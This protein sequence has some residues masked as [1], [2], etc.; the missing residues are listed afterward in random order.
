MNCDCQRQLVRELSHPSLFDE[1]IEAARNACVAGASIASALI[2]AAAWYDNPLTG[3]PAVRE[4]VERLGR[5][6]LDRAAVVA[7]LG[8]TTHRA[9]DEQAHGPGFGF[10]S[11][12]RSAC[13]IMAAERLAKNPCDARRACALTFYVRHR[14]DLEP[15]LGPLNQAGLC[16]LT[17]ADHGIDGDQAE[18]AF[19]LAR[20]EVATIEAQKTRRRGL[21]SFPFFSEEYAYEGARPAPRPLELQRWLSEVGLE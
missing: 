4:C 20:L 3:A 10:I 13:V 9:T 2:T 1:G 17:Y 21:R 18:R 11:A 14:A 6:E 12:E 19:M 16:A 15:V 8:S 7:A 5:A